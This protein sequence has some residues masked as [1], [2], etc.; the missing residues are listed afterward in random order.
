MRGLIGDRAFY[1]MVLTVAVPIMVQNGVSSFVSLLDNLMIGRVGTNA[2]SGV[3]ISNQLI[4]VYYL[5][6][7]GASAGAGIFTAQYHGCGDTEGVRNTFRFKLLINTALTLA[8]IAVYALF[9]DVLIGLFLK[10]EGDPADAAETL[11]LGKEYLYIML[12]GL[13]PVGL[14]NSY[15]GTLRETGETRVPMVASIVAILVN[16]VGNALLIY[17]LFGLPALGAAGA[18]IATVASRF[19]EL[20]VLAVYTALHAK[21]H[22]FIT[23][24]FRHFHVPARQAGKFM[25]KCLPLMAN[26]TLWALGQTMMNQSYSYRSLDAVAALNI[27]TTIWNL[28]GVAF[29]AMGDA[30]G[31]VIGQILGSGDVEKAKDHAKKMI[32]FTIGWGILFGIITLIAAPFFPL[33]YKTSTAIRQMATKLILIY[34]ILM[35]FYAFTHASYFTIRAGGNTLITFVFDSCFVW[36]ISVPVAYALSRFTR[37]DVVLMVLIVQSLELIKCLIGYA[38]VRSGIWAKNI[39]GK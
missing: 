18:A 4:F 36:L 23:G 27:E 29:I 35:P 20:A 11:L 26:E 8:S 30:V 25:L 24:A 28:M 32:A 16:L 13:V 3:A 6:V 39:V 7:F 33:F 31:I 15:S 21:Q 1:R 2:L 14:T 10:G 17:G 9:A 22:P 19:V 34:G 5:L 37:M 38:M 12:I